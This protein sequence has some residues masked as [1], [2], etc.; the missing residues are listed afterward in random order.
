VAIRTLVTTAPGD[1]TADLSLGVGGA[2]TADSTP[3]EEYE[4][5]RAKAFGVL[6]A[7]GTEFPE[8]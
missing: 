8:G 1:G 6:S 7:L 2:V 3:Q 5:I 4:E